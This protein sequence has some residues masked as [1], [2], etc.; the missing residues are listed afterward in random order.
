M[1]DIL[2]IR[3]KDGNF[4]GIPSIKGDNGKS[5]YEQAVEGGYKGTEEEFIQ[6]LGNLGGVFALQLAI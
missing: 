5:A 3:D 1:S 6:I 2:K 4:V